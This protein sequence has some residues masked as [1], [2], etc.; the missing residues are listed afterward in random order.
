MFK[1]NPNYNLEDEITK[2]TPF[3][4]D[5]PSILIIDSLKPKP[6]ENLFSHYVNIH[7]FWYKNFTRYIEGDCNATCSKPS[8]AEK[9]STNIE[10]I[11]FL[12]ILKLFLLNTLI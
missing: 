9:L 3:T 5:N 10:L 7:D 8:K 1:R 6:S 4:S 12:F 2:W 11:G